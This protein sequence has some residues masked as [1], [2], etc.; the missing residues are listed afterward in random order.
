MSLIASDNGTGASYP[1]IE[2]GTYVARCVGLVDLGLQHNDFTGKDRH[3]VSITWELPTERIEQ[4]GEDKPRWVSKR[5]T[6]S[7][8]EKA[9]L[10][11]D[12]DAWRGR[13]FTPEELK[14]FDLKRIVGTPCMLTI[15]NKEGNNGGKYANVSGVGRLMKGV[16]VAELESPS[17][18]FD[19]DAEDAEAVLETLPKWM[20]ETVEKSVTWQDRLKDP[21]E[22]LPEVDDCGN[23]LPWED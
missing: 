21:D 14:G 11:K 3:E 19:M 13:A 20:R 12:L 5:Y 16:S 2:P 6:L 15:V 4:D 18:I 23:K 9:T 10:R 7:L 8:N 17:F 22:P 1:V